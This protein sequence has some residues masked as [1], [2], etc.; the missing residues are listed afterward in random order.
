MELTERHLKAAELREYQGLTFQKI[1]GILGVYQTE[2]ALLYREVLRSRREERKKEFF[3]QEN[4][5]VVSVEFSLGELAVLQ[6]ML[7]HYQTWMRKTTSPTLDWLGELLEDIDYIAAEKMILRLLAAECKNRN[8]FPE[9]TP[10]STEARGK[11]R[12]RSGPADK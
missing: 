4:S 11:G 5:R 1:G 12:P 7:A 8:I 10:L 2:A 3:R 6:R 9:D